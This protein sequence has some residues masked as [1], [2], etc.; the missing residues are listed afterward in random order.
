VSGTELEEKIS[1]ESG[2]EARRR[3]GAKSKSISR[4]QTDLD[5][6]L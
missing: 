4:K 5:I 6:G 3:K 2:W 1:I